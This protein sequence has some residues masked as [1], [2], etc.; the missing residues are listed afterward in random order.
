PT[1][2]QLEFSDVDMVV[3]GSGDSSCWKVGLRI[4]APSTRPTRTAAIGPF[5]GTLDISSAADA[6]VTPR[7]SASFS[8]SADRTYT[9]TWISFLN[10]SGKSG[11]I[12]RS[13]T[14]AERISS[15]EGRPSRFRKPPGIL[16]AA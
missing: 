13:I 11:R 8:W 1:F 7:T 16:P 12:E 3:S 4:H 15:S 5:Q 10:P 2:Q 6:A 9:Y 14:R